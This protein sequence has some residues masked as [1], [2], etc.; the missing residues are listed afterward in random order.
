MQFWRW[1]SWRVRVVPTT[2]QLSL[3]VL[4]LDVLASDLLYGLTTILYGSL[5]VHSLSQCS[6]VYT[7]IDW[8]DHNYLE[9]HQHLGLPATT[10]LH[11]LHWCTAHTTSSHLLYQRSSGTPVPMPTTPCTTSNNGSSHSATHKDYL[12][13]CSSGKWLPYKWVKFNM[14]IHSHHMHMWMH[15]NTHTHTQY[16]ISFYTLSIIHHRLLSSMGTMNDFAA[17]SCK[18]IQSM[19]SNICQTRTSGT[20][21][22]NV[23]DSCG[24]MTHMKVG[25]ILYCIN[26]WQLLLQLWIILYYTCSSWINE[27]MAHWC[28]YNLHIMI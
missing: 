2:L 8:V 13:I 16:Y 20:F 24:N 5:R 19:L 3:L 4:G 28:M 27:R 21:C 23:P 18:E 12:W 26:S 22:V 10:T 25:T 15:A 9:V 7:Y 1:G 6:T 14:S 11:T 17:C